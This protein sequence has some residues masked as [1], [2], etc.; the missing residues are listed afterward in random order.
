M[1]EYYDMPF[2]HAEM[3]KLRSQVPS[4]SQCHSYFGEF[5]A[6]GQALEHVRKQHGAFIGDVMLPALEIGNDP[7]MGHALERMWL[8]LLT[9]PAP[10]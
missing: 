10:I 2:F 3:E 6:S 4:A 5:I 9:R 7:P 1:D 8:A